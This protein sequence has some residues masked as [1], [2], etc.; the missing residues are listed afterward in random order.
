MGLNMEVEIGNP[1]ANLGAIV[2]N[3]DIDDVLTNTELQNTL[4]ETYINHGQLLILRGCRKLEWDEMQTLIKL[5]YP[6]DH[7]NIEVNLSVFFSTD[8]VSA[9]T[10][11]W[12]CDSTF[13]EYPA[14]ISNIQLVDK[15][16]NPRLGNTLWCNTNLAYESLPMAIKEIA[17][18]YKCL[19]TAP[20]ATRY[21]ENQDW[22]K[23][24]SGSQMSYDPLED[25]G[26]REAWH[27][28][29]HR[30]NI[31]G[32]NHILL[33]AYH[34]SI[35]QNKRISSILESNIY[36]AINIPEFQYRHQWEL[37]DIAIFDN[38]STQHYACSDYF[39]ESRTM[40]R[41]M[42]FSYGEDGKVLDPGPITLPNNDPK[43]QK[44]WGFINKRR[45]LRQGK[46]I[47]SLRKEGLL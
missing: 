42:L 5:F 23:N 9:A 15:P 13:R 7:N 11:A 43:T 31:T 28:I 33:N 21:A 47:E 20:D 34:S 25:E 35:P 36:G 24:V 30:H 6:V 22:V 19:N 26:V 8:Q 18:R 45:N 39:P 37:N 3:V 4:Y 44:F 29:I 16:E 40:N 27:P 46:L 38:L 41:S 17:H 10:N 1:A 14:R 32:K 2:T 12:H